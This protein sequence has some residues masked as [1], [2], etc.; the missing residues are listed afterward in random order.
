MGIKLDWQV[1]SEQ[2]Q[3]RATDDPEA[4]RRRRQTQRR[5]ALIIAG[6]AGV[7]MLIAALVIWRLRRVDDQLRQDLL[8]TV[9]IEVTALRLGDLAEFMTV[10]RSAS[11]AFLLEQNRMF[12]L[13]QELKRTHRI[14]LTGNVLDV[15]ID[16]P[17]GRVILEEIVDGAPY[18]VVWFYW[19]YEDDSD[20]TGWRRVPAD[21]TFWGDAAEMAVGPTQ[22]S[23]HTLDQDLAA[24][25]AERLPDWWTQGCEVLGCATPPPTLRVNIVAEYP[26]NRVTWEADTAWTLRITSPLVDRA[27][28]DQPIAPDLERLIAQ[29]V[30]T[31][32]VQYAVGDTIPAYYTDAAWLQDEIARWLT[33]SAL[34]DS[35]GAGFVNAL[36]AYYGSDVPRALLRSTGPAATLDQALTAASGLAIPLMSVDQL[37]ALDW[38]SFFQWRLNLEAQLLAQPD[39]SGAFLALYDADNVYAMGDAARRLEDP[40]YAG[41]GVPQIT[42]L[43]ISRDDYSQ[44]YAYAETIRTLPD[45]STISAETVI[46]R[47]IGGTWKRTS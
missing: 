31:R 19:H 18:K 35:D 40:A 9:Q 37:N 2:T 45:G 38:E 3:L 21:L 28:V 33:G 6:L 12:E 41:L 32:L 42:T 39:S 43:I 22:I 29:T 24:A 11:A 44:T 10:Q 1:E 20:Q 15:E 34:G 7:L 17:R 26:A 5:L 27:R 47:A 36:I 46:W 25:L 14:Q 4:K 13:Y 8:D 30:T 23:Y 16:D